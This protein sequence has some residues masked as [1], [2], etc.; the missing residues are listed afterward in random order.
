MA[1]LQLIWLVL[2]R[3]FLG[4]RPGSAQLFC[5]WTRLHFHRVPWHLYRDI[6]VYRCYEPPIEL[7]RSPRILDIGANIG[8][9]SL[10]FLYRYPDAQMT[11]LEPNP[12]A[13]ALLQRNVLPA[14]YPAA[15]I[16][17]RQQAVSSTDGV[18]SLTVPAGDKTAAFASV[19]G[20][21]MEGIAS[22]AVEVPAVAVWRLLEE[23]VALM[24][25]DIEGY[26]YEILRDLPINRALVSVLVV[27]FHEIEK[28]GEQCRRILSHLINGCGYKAQDEKKEPLE[29][30]R[31]CARQGTYL[32]T[33]F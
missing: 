20:R 7:C 10:F 3:G 27:E 18:L 21:G 11:S 8:I 9:A 30:D 31:F 17:L 29:I 14:R 33:F 19:S 24:K 25:V 16:H 23:P 26:E 12:E 6:F 28:H 5:P 15:S 4:R 2:L 1:F 13:F 32:T 22:D